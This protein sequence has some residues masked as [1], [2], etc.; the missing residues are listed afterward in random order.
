MNQQISSDLTD[1]QINLLRR[2]VSADN[3]DTCLSFASLNQTEEMDIVVL[4]AKGMVG[5]DEDYDIIQFRGEGVSI[6]ITTP[7]K[8]SLKLLSLKDLSTFKTAQ[9]ML[10]L[11][12][13]YYKQRW[14]F[15][16]EWFGSRI[17]LDCEGIYTISNL[18][19]DKYS[20]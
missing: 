8:K 17:E 15:D 6:L 10:D 9:G 14:G 12:I 2:I 7:F 20:C 1:T 11:C 16:G 3:H 13:L 5:L 4:I 18:F 19:E